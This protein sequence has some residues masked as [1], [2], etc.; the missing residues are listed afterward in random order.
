[1]QVESRSGVISL[2]QFVNEALRFPFSKLDVITAAAPLPV[3]S[4]FSLLLDHCAAT[5]GYF[6]LFAFIRDFV[7]DGGGTHGVDKCSFSSGY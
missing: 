2:L 1:M 3:V 7:S 5:S 4:R 6:A